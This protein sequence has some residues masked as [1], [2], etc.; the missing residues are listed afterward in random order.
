MAGHEA[1]DSAAEF[2]AVAE[3][4]LERLRSSPGGRAA[5]EN[6][7]PR[8]RESIHF[9]F[10]CSDFVAEACIVEPELLARPCLGSATAP[11]TL[12]PQSEPG[13][14]AFAAALRRWRRQEMVRIA[15][16]DLAGWASLE[17][18]LRELSDLADAAIESAERVA[19]GTSR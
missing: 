12:V 17:E 3:R 10:G 2:N 13:E 9:V 16:R 6:A 19:R 5:L 4:H 18:T 11:P 15:W 8:V 7:D 1:L 14:L